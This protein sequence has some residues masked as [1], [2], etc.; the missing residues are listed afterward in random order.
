MSRYIYRYI[1]MHTH[2]ECICVC[3]YICMHICQRCLLFKFNGWVTSAT[4]ILIHRIT[5]VIQQTCD[6]VQNLSWAR[7]CVCVFSRFC[8]VWHCDPM[9]CSTPSS[10]VHGILYTGVGCHAL[11]QGIV[12]THVSCIAGRFFTAEPPGKP[13]WSPDQSKWKWCL[14]RSFN[15]QLG[16]SSLVTS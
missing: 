4:Y 2:Y 12:P 16:I 5:P 6:L 13:R 8:R 1:Q 7:V 10:S 3:I 15:G 9:D 11:L 14:F